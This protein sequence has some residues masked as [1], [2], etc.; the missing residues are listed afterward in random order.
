MNLAQG[1]L[2]HLKNPAALPVKA[3]PARLPDRSPIVS[4]Y[5][6]AQ[7]VGVMAEKTWS[8]L[9]SAYSGWV[10]TC[11][12][13]ISKSVAR[14][15]LKLYVYRSKQT[16]KLIRDVQFK[17]AYRALKDEGERKY[18]MKDL[19]LEKEEITDHPFLA[20]MNRPNDFMPRFHLWYHTM[21]RLE[22]GGLCCWLK[23]RDGLGVTRQIYPLPLTK[24]ADIRPKVA[25]S[26]AL[27]HWIYRDGNINRTFKPEEIF[28]ILYPHPASPF[29]GMAPLMAQTY[30]Y[31]ID[32]FLMQQQR[33]LYENGAVPGL[34]MHTEQR[35]TQDQVDEITGS[36]NEQFRGPLR[37]GEVLV[38][39]SGMK[40]E[41]LAQ[42]GRENMIGQIAE[43]VRDKLLTAY[44]ISAGI[45]GIVSDVNRANG[46]FLKSNWVQ[47]CIIPKCMI[48]EESIETFLLPDYD[49]GLT[50]DFDLP[51]LEDKE[52]RLKERETNLRIKYSTI[53]QELARDGKEPVE[54]GD[55]PWGS[56]TDMQIGGEPPVPP[57][58]ESPAKSM[59]TKRMDRSFWTDARKD[60]HW[61]MFVARSEKLE[62]IFL[63]PMKAYFRNQVEEVVRRL[64]REG[65][66][67]EDQYAG[68][69]RQKVERHL[70][71]H[72]ADLEKINI[73]REKEAKA[74]AALLTPVVKTIMKKRGDER[75]RDLNRSVKGMAEE[76]K[77]IHIDFNVNDPRVLEWL[78]SRMRQF[79]EE[80]SGTT[81]DQIEAILREGFSAGEPVTTISQTLREKFDGYDKWRAP[82]IART[83]TIS[84]M[85][86]ADLESVHQLELEGQLLKHWLTAGDEHVRESHDVAGA[87]YADGIAMDEEFVL[88]G[89]EDRMQAPGNGS[90]ASQNI[91]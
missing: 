35:L 59:E 15:P 79:S 88:R 36:I 90:E 6:T 89:P 19:K 23:V 80:V 51:D 76:E 66:R 38:T 86:R 48:I 55:K 63:K 18:F 11:I 7:S 4:T 56:Y 21:I 62:Q 40:A 49:Q 70:R 39:H 46:E 91:S 75:V 83:E 65:K 58:K 54:W 2:E 26:M 71:N 64:D 1:Y 17:A 69:S 60:I 32:F 8:Q 47:D 45:L 41:R 30:P 25:P 84:A 27:E 31:D 5:Y 29:Q 34:N 52:F 16:G 33:A 78:G 50:C 53:N 44:D 42:T 22:L 20:L 85:N 61:K 9:V 10:Y 43:L 77:A 67:V 81:F 37:A 13:K 87:E 28:S 24:F 12:D 3:A 14:I 68:W 73:D 72:K 82:L 74:L 57:A